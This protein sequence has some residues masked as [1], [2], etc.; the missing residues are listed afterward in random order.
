MPAFSFQLA[1]T[2]CFNQIEQMRFAAIIA[3]DNDVNRLDLG[4]ANPI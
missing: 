1:F 3:S 2:E 4:E